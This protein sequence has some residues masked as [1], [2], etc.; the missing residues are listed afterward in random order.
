M[1]TT[2]PATSA[3]E[4]GSANGAARP[5]GPGTVR[6]MLSLEDL[7]REVEA[8]GI[9]TIVTA[10]TD[11]QGRL[12]GKRIQAEYFF[13]DIVDHAIEGCNYLLALDMEMEPVPGY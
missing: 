8:G 7:R 12:I 4:A 13:E 6:G 5:G 11:M 9:D 2:D 1:S 10:F 3:G